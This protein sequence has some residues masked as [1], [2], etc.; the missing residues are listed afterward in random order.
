MSQGSG[1]DPEVG[2]WEIGFGDKDGMEN[3]GSLELILGE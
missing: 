3:S 2:G 1:R